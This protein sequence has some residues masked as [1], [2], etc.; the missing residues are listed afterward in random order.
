MKPAWRDRNKDLKDKPGGYKGKPGGHSSR[1]AGSGGFSAKGD[2]PRS[3]QRYHGPNAPKP[4]SKYAHK[5]KQRS[6]SATN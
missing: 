6:T 3:V 4:T 1:D 2:K 5:K